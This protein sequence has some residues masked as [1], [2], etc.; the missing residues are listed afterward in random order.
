MV[1]LLSTLIIVIMSM[2]LAAFGQM[3]T[4][5]LL[6]AC[7]EKTQVMKLIQGKPEVV[8]EK[9]AGLCHGYLVGVYDALVESKVICAPSDLPT[10][11]YLYSVLQTL[12]EGRTFGLCKV[13]R[14]G[15]PG[16]LPARIRVR[17]KEKVRNR[18][19]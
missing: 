9:I 16:R 17:R 12:L 5:T 19:T 8:G 4:E 1:L 18:T 2:A 7:K 15:H 6:N 11:E 3:H 10:P 13:S 14:R